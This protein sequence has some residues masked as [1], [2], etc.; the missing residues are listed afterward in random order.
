MR[1]TR[2]LNRRIII[3]MDGFDRFDGMDG[4]A[5]MDGISGVG[6]TGAF[7]W[8]V[9][10]QTSVALF[11]RGLDVRSIWSRT[12]RSVQCLAHDTAGAPDVCLLTTR[13]SVSPFPPW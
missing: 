11:L 10:S 5:D 7:G 6:E 8:L 4:T 2:R 9:S 12:E 1:R 13:R 3:R